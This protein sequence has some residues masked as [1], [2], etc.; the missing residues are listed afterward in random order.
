MHNGRATREPLQLTSSPCFNST[1]ELIIQS[2]HPY[3][4]SLPHLA[5]NKFFERNG[6]MTNSLHT[7]NKV[8]TSS[9]PQNQA[10]AVHI[11][12]EVQKKHS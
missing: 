5:F 8:K 7:E 3:K 2:T 10:T 9:V 4:T 6:L 12:A 1:L 11:R